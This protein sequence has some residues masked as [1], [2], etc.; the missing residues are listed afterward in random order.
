MIYL[1]ALGTILR[2]YTLHYVYIIVTLLCTP[3]SAIHTRNP[4]VH[5]C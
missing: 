2:P 3:A 5:T 1:D 4:A